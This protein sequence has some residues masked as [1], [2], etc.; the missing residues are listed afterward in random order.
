MKVLAIETS[1]DETSVAVVEDGR[2]IHSNLIS[3]QIETHKKFGG[4]VPEIASRMHLEQMN[5]I[6]ALSL[7]EAKVEASDID[8]VAV[9]RGPG[10]VGALLVGVSA[11]KAI[12]VAL[13]IPIVGVNHMQGH[14]CANYLAYEDLEP[15]FLTLVVSGGH[16]YLCRVDSYA[17]YTVLG[18]TKDDAAGESFDKISRALGLGYPG[19]PAIEKA[20][21][22]GNPDAFTFPQP[23]IDED[24]YDF[25]FSGLKTAVTNVINEHKMQGHALNPNDIAASFQKTVTD[26]LVEKSVRLVNETGLKK[27]ALS[28]GVAAN[29][30]LYEKLKERLEPLGVSIYKPP[31]VLCTDN[32]AMIGSAGYYQYQNEGAS[33]LDFET[34]PNLGL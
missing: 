18:S 19:G 21:L 11:A 10:L 25:S 26:V 9:T 13:D 1:C 17:D 29:Q 24:N 33:A 20:A 14:I 23:M 22:S 31:L 27:F 15:P 16:T 3:T 6:L 8:L 32:A 12:S 2:V 28:G 5:R 30:A 34:D 4:V 7:E